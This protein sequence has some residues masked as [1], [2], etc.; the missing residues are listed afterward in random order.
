MP[1]A[2][3]APPR[4]IGGIAQK[5]D[6]T[7]RWPI[8]QNAKLTTNSTGF[9][10]KKAAR[11]SPTAAIVL[12]NATW[13]FRSPVLSECAPMTIIPAMAAIKGIEFTRP[14]LKPLRPVSSSRIFGSQR[15]MP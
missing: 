6:I 9:L 10:L 13:N 3:A 7:E 4:K 14:S 12:Q 1:A 11:A 2:A 8:W 5:T 15:K